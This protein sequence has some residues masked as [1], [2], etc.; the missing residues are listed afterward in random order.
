MLTSTAD[1]TVHAVSVLSP[2][3]QIHGHSISP[4]NVVVEVRKVMTPGL[5]P[6]CHS[7]FDEG[8]PVSVGG[9]YEWPFSHLTFMQDVVRR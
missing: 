3:T 5:R 8:E 2:R 1:P 6:L 7:A 9:F 4:G